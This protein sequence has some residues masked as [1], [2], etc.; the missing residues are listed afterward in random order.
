[1]ENKTKSSLSKIC[2]VLPNIMVISPREKAPEGFKVINTTSKDASDIGRAFSPFYLSNIPLYENHMAR[3]MENAWQFSK[4]YKEYADK[5]NN[6]TKEYFSWAKKGWNDSFA[7]RYANGKGNIPLYSF[8]KTFNESTQTWQE[9][10]WDY[11]TARKN[12]YFPLYAKAII[13]TQA[14]KALK[15][16]IN[17]GEKIALWD[18]DGYDHEA[19]NMSYEE[20]VNEPK[21]K[22]GHAFVLYGLLTEQLKI[23]NNELIYD[24]DLKLSTPIIPMDST[25]D[26]NTSQQYTFFFHLT[27]P[28]SNFHPSCFKYKDYMFISNE[29]F[30]MMSKAKTFNDETVAEKIMNIEKEFQAKNGTFKTQND[31]FCFNL[32]TSFK[33]GEISRKEILNDK[34]KQTAWN[35]IHKKIKDLGRKVANYDDSIWSEKREKVVLFGARLKFTQNEDLKEDLIQTNTTIM[36][37]ASPYDKIWGIGLSAMDAKK[38]PPESWPGLNLLGKVL[39]RLKLEFGITLNQEAEIKKPPQNSNPAN[40]EVLNFYTLKKII[41]ENGVYIGRAN[42]GHSLIGSKFANPFPMKNQSEEERQRVVNEYKT[43]VWQQ[44]LDKKITKED[45]LN[46]KNQK[47]VCYCAPK[48]CHGD[49][50]K[51]LVNY[52]LNNETEFDEKVKNYQSKKLRM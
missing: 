45:L 21:Y 7:H 10:K 38:I 50:L 41:P 9:H 11:I 27:S 31:E 24:F 26:K 40:I 35:T 39:D 14:F 28:F 5:Q 49:V 3:N 17:S 20:V 4:V 36:V 13:K 44:V 22:C 8:W 1:M 12:I 48:A 16:R 25:M 51:D 19:R 6:P 43:W 33:N 2:N 52:V 32:I 30:M 18:F 37:E 47:L 15:D 34:E 23:I 46:L 42:K 29:Q